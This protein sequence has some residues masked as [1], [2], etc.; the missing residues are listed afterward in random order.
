MGWVLDS[1]AVAFTTVVVALPPAWLAAVCGPAVDI[2][3]RWHLFRPDTVQ[4]HPGD[5][6]R[7][8]NDDPFV[9]QVYVA[10]DAFTYNGSLQ[11]TGATEDIA[12][13]VPGVFQVRCAF[14]PRMAL[15]VE[16][17]AP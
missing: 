10:S 7:F 9:H 17:S 15:R 6:I 16:V 2:E 11:E 14:Y 12:F 1:C 13:P 4:I 8:T 3:Q 5:I